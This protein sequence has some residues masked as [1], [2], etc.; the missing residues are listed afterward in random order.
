MLPWR[1][2][3]QTVWAWTRT[4]PTLFVVP[5][6]LVRHGL[7]L[8]KLSGLHC[9]RFKTDDLSSTMWSALNNEQLL[10]FWCI[11]MKLQMEF[12]SDYWLFIVKVLWT[13][14]LCIIGWENQGTGAK[15]WTWTVNCRLEGLSWQLNLNRQKVR[16]IQEKPMY[17]LESHTWR[18]K[19][20]F[21]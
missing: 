3:V 15:I 16:H 4:C 7:R 8:G 1:Y 6:A 12:I 13:W 20:W 19:Y 9:M 10:N 11:K 14:V 2:L 17:F 21:N 5:W 18:V